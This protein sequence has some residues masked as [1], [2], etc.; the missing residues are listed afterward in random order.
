MYKKLNQDEI[1]LLRLL[2]DAYNFGN[3]ADVNCAYT[4]KDGSVAKLKGN[5]ETMDMVNE[6]D[7]RLVSQIC[8]PISKVITSILGQELHD[9]WINGSNYDVDEL[10]KITNSEG[11]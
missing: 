4:N 1:K 11:V 10:I 9:F 5:Y 6:L 8:N 3:I 7:Q 2:A